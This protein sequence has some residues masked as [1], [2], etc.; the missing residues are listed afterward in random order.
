M[1]DAKSVTW[2]ATIEALRRHAPFDCMDPDSLAFL[3]EAMELAYFP[4]G[5]RVTGPE[6]GTAGVLYVVQSGVIR[7][8]D[9][10]GAGL[11]PQPGAGTLLFGE[12]ECFPL[13]EVLAA[14]P[15]SQDYFAE[16]DSFCYTVQA[17]VVAQLA[18]RSNEFQRFCVDSLGALLSR[19]QASVQSLHARSVT[20]AESMG[21]PLRTLLR[22]EPV[23]CS[24]SDSLQ[25]ALGR[26]RDAGTGSI[27]VVSPEG[28]PVGVFTER[29]LLRI[30]ASAEFDRMQPVIDCMTPSPRTLPVTATATEAALLMV[31]HGVR[32]VP[33]TD[34]GRLVGVVSERDLFALQRNSLRDL[35]DTIDRAADEAALKQASYGIA[36]LLGSLL[37]QGVGA[38]HLTQIV[39]SMNDRLVARILDLESARHDLR[40]IRVCW[41]ALGSEGRQE[42]TL[43]TDQ[44]NAIVF[45]GDRDPASIRQTLLPFAQAVNRTL[46]AC[47]FPLCKGGVMAGHPQW[48]LSEEEWR[49]RCSD[50]IRTPVPQAVLHAA[51]FFDLRALWGATDLASS[52]RAW[53]TDALEGQ[54]GLLRA[55]AQ[56]ALESRVTGGLIGRL[57]ALARGSDPRWIDLKASGTRPF[58]DAARILALSA[59]TEHTSTA[60]RLRAAGAGLH[61]PSDEIGAMVDAFHF[62]LLLRLR[63]QMA[64]PLAS[65]P[66]ANRIDL[67]SLNELDR[68]IL[69]EAMRQ[70]SRLQDRLALDYR[71]S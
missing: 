36:Q 19:S 1:P 29:D 32:H 47:G 22:R 28:A 64:R 51:I 13:A 58:V 34:E 70:A 10:G 48:C 42:Q 43:A 3:V 38:A 61:I 9:P 57:L 54:H 56:S 16:E 59:R 52:L 66:D 24:I 7:A 25:I 35:V 33:V 21:A 27:V 8:V 18:G 4:G 30:A 23:T 39:V 40:G 37:A 71:L 62:V 14:R 31:R 55:M 6:I 53:L 17:G 26:M 11:A 63:H 68:R 46:D 65:G 49:A 50:W 20:G 67:D 69:R 12:G 45:S 15:A 41:V 44:D 60:A 5:R 2:E